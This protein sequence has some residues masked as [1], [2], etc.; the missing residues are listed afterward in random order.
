MSL[1]KRLF[2]PCT[3]LLGC[4]FTGTLLLAQQKNSP[5]QAQVDSLINVAKLLFAEDSTK[6]RVF[7]EQALEQAKRINYSDGT[8]AS[9][10]RLGAYYLTMGS[11]QK[12]KYYYNQNLQF[13]LKT[14]DLSRQAK[15]YL[16]LSEVTSKLGDRVATLDNLIKA[17]ELVQKTDDVQSHTRILNLLGNHFRHEQD[18]ERAA[19]Y[20]NE[21]LEIRLTINDSSGLANSYQVLGNLYGEQL[22]SGAAKKHYFKSL[23]Y[24]HDNRYAQQRAGILTNLGIIYARTNRLD[25]AIFCYE[26]AFALRKASGNI[27]SQA[28]LLNNL[29][30]LAFQQEQYQRSIDY[31][32]TG[33]VLAEQ[34]GAPQLLSS[35]YYNLSDSYKEIGDFKQSFYYYKL[36]DSIDYELT[37]AEK[38]AEMARLQVQFETAQKDKEIAQQSLNLVKANTQRNWL[39]SGSALLLIIAGFVYWSLIR[40][41]RSNRALQEQNEL[42]IKREYEKTLLLRELHHRVKNNFQVVSSLLNLQY[43]ETENPEAA[44]A[45]KSGRTRVEAMSMIHSEL[46]QG[47]SDTAME[48][49]DYIRHLIE[50]VVFLYN[51]ELEDITLDLS[52]DERPL[53]VKYAIPIG[54]IVNELITNAF[55]H[56]FEVTEKPSLTVLL[57]W[58][59]ISE[60]LTLKVKDNG[61][62]L[63]PT[64][65]DKGSS[66]GLELITD[67]VKQ[68]QGKLLVEN[69]K[70]AEFTIVVPYLTVYQNVER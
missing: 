61:A 25:S 26:K 66:F 46:Y 5:E 11:L 13:Y 17:L 34:S 21:A 31:A 56:A 44:N 69:N 18:Y 10:R 42:I 60:E 1:I 47:N 45:I 54:I 64:A 63:P 53:E 3:I 4:F 14:D 55:K 68:L 58:D 23:D 12:A 62:G 24:L 51:F 41:R 57:K 48:M 22:Q 49:E 50:N 65:S 52:I 33:L 19:D 28:L 32:Q 40:K 2:G 9:Y 37:N 15:G 43:Y 30:A 27:Y 59:V 6:S 29:T 39:L 35:L 7:A 36:S 67:L 70:G 38:N 8:T 20:Y 16:S